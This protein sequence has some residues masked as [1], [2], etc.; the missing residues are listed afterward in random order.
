M[1]GRLYYGALQHAG[2]TTLARRFRDGALV[3]C[4]HNVVPESAA[5]VGDTAL[6]LSADQFTHQM[7]WLKR[8]YRVVSLHELVDRLARGA[9][10]R[11][12]AAITFDDGYA[13]VFVHAW[14]L[15]R[16]MGLPATMFIVADAP[17]GRAAF[18]W[19]HPAVAQSAHN[20]ARDRRLH[21]L[22]GDRAAI[23]SEV[24]AEPVQALPNTHLPADWP[25]V[26]QAAAAGGAGGGLDIGAHTITH[27]TLT[28]LSDRELTEELVT[29]RAM[30]GA[31]TG[32]APTLLSY[33]YGIW[34]ARVAEAARRAG[35]RAAVT[36]DFGLNIHGIDP[37]ELRRI[38]I[39]A[40]I[41][42]PAFAAWA[43]G[44]RPRS[45]PP[46]AV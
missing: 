5:Q 42:P 3:L 29:A 39:P 25:V 35:Y 43:A 46:P 23:L 8:H 32:A 10:V 22:R 24:S 34:D 40:S 27:R 12:I 13:G 37:L 26:A 36:L 45:V 9:S 6:H 33:P 4:Y 44:F 2:I 28:T 17:A 18:W 31:H 19:D 14:P 11:G 15:L 16:D 38:N 30:I 1:L 41:S 21:S 20:G 7:Q